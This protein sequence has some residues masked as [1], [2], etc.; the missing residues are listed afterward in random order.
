M[1]T[2][3]ATPVTR[4]EDMSKSRTWMGGL[5]SGAAG[6]PISF[7][8]DGESVRGIPDEWRPVS[9]RRRVDA[10]VRETIFE[11]SDPGTGLNVRVECTQY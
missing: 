10:N 4:P 2:M 9:T 1:D 3:H 5:F 11:G 8:L 7:V 6:L